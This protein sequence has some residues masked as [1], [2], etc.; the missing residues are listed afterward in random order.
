MERLVA[1]DPGD[2]LNHGAF[3]FRHRQVDDVDGDTTQRG[4]V[5]VEFFRTECVDPDNDGLAVGRPQV[6]Q[7]RSEIDAGLRFLALG[8]RVFQ[9]EREGVSRGIERLSEQFGARG[10]DEQFAPHHHV[11]PAMPSVQTS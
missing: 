10:R 5:G 7:E 9:I 4:D 3:I 2:G 11:I 6:A 8:N 1:F